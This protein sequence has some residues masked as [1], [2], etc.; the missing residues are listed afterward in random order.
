MSMMLLSSMIPVDLRFLVII[1]LFLSV[2]AFVM[3]A[4]SVFLFYKFYRDTI[5]PLPALIP[6]VSENNISLRLFNNGNSPFFISG[7]RV[8]KNN[9][10]SGSISDFLPL[11]DENTG[12]IS[13][14]IIREGLK[15]MPEQSLKIFEFDLSA[16]DAGIDTG[17]VRDI[18][19]HLDGLSFEVHCRDIGKRYKTVIRKNLTIGENR[20]L[21]QKRNG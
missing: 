11:I 15:V 7:F 1:T 16:F 18:L 4:F 6:S 19:V 10:S 8:S 5:K 9:R 20:W 14:T 13:V 21:N 12:Y 17:V 2:A 3:S